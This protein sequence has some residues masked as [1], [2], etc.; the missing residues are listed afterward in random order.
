MPSKKPGKPGKTSKQ[1]GR[2][3][4]SSS[5]RH[6]TPAGSFTAPNHPPGKRRAPPDPTQ[7]LASAGQLPDDNSRTNGSQQQ[8]R[9]PMPGEWPD[10]PGV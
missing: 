4:A 5:T 2:I 10:E 8:R 7:S 6:R 9:G 1:A 3:A